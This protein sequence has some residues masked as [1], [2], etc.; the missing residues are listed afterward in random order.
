[1]KKLTIVILVF[2]VL[3]SYNENCSAAAKKD[4]TKKECYTFTDGK[5][6]PMTPVKDQNKSGTCW[7]FSSG[8]FLEAELLRMG[9]GTYDF[10]EMFVVR[11]CYEDKAKQYVR[12]HGNMN[13]ASGGAFHDILYVMQNYGLVPEDAYTGI[14]YDEDKHIHSEL[15]AVL[16]ANV[17]A[18]RA[19]KGGKLTTRWF[20][21]FSALLDVYL[22]KVPETFTYNGRTY[23]PRSFADGLGLNADNYVE[24][25]SFTHHPFYE[26]FI[27]EIPDNWTMSKIQNVPIDELMQ[28]IDNALN[29]GYAVGWGA[30]VSE[31]GFSRKGYAVLND[32]K[33]PDL[34][35]KAR[36]D[37]D[38]LTDKQKDS[39]LYTF[40][41]PLPQWKVTQEERQKMFDNYETTDDHGMIICGFA[42]DQE[43]HKFY[44]VKNSWSEKSGYKGYFYVSE[45]FVR[46]KTIDVMLHK[47]AIPAAIKSKIGL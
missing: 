37:W 29:N 1:M 5:Q 17:D 42:T 10:S 11:K 31:K 3:L 16:R 27:L 46:A 19:N 38:T 41:K 22:G 36:D 45:E 9:K 25:G 44:K 40:E 30:D 32:P 24:I 6:V 28:I 23:T 34:M 20:D 12:M 35:G 15:D 4:T 8:G 14:M 18:V 7:S 26:K 21:G 43:G 13:F 39:V 47:D 2:V 33:R